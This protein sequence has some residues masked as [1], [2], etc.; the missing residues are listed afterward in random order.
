MTI[1]D[2]KEADY[3]GNHKEP[4]E[5]PEAVLE[6][7]PWI[8]TAPHTYHDEGEEEE[9]A[10]HGHADTVGSQVAHQL[11]TLKKVTHIDSWDERRSIGKVSIQR[12][13]Q[14][15]LWTVREGEKRENNV[16]ML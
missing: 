4:L 8:S 9:E 1:R 16:D 15:L 13:T 6:I 7:R 11:V 10:S 2:E 14:Q 5:E 12:D 3:N